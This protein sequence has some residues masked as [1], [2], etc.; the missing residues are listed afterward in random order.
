MNAN[1]Q[2]FYQNLSNLPVLL[3]SMQVDSSFK[4]GNMAPLIVVLEF[5]E[6]WINI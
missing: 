3:Y 1:P 4:I 2:S 6:S 5:K